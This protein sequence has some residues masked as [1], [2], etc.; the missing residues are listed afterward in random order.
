[1]TTDRPPVDISP[2]RLKILDL[3]TMMAGPFAAT[4][5]G[6]L[7]AEVIKV[8]QPGTGDPTR[9]TGMAPRWEA[10]G[11]NKR[12]VTLNLRV[13]AGARMLGDLVRW[14]DVLIEN[15]RPGTMERWGLG[16]EQLSAV[17]EKLVY[18]SVSGFGQTG[19]YRERAGYDFVAGAF[20]GL[21][22]VTGYPD[23]PPV[24]PGMPVADY[25]TAAFATVAILEALRQRDQP[26]GTGRGTWIDC[27]LYETLIRMSGHDIVKYSRTGEVR[28]RD[29]G[30]PMGPG[31]SEAPHTFTY[32]TR[33]GRW[34][35][36]YVALD[37]HFAKLAAAVGDPELTRAE[38]A[39][40]KGRFDHAGEFDAIIRSWIAG[41]D[42][43]S[44]LELMVGAGLPFSPVNSVADLVDDP[45][46]KARESI[47]PVRTH[48]G[49]DV[50]MQ[51][52]Y[53]KVGPDVGVRWAGE[54][55]GASNELV[56]GQLLGLDRDRLLALQAE[57]VI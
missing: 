27:S 49:D 56:Y 35:S 40:K 28:G 19:P 9:E 42:Y 2:Q 16:Y 18:L 34:V 47:I 15:F 22:Y 14:A 7:G 48:A 24:L 8:E 5:L 23:R 10:E 31:R 3:G 32:Q 21:T 36:L 52:P 39:T 13:P 44:L 17:N 33:D 37:T 12:S 43:A 30:R 54:P 25:T 50:L 38:F 51:A 20:G 29:G 53:P 55:L 45:H 1:M 57:G 11:R 41:Q 4:L 46:V 26:G 6:D